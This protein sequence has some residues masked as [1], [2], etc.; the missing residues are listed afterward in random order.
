MDKYKI[1][2]ILLERGLSKLDKLMEESK[3]IVTNSVRDLIIY[4]RERTNKWYEEAKLEGELKH[5]ERYYSINQGLNK[6]LNK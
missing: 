6:I 4:L 2:D 3:E 5:A 1:Q